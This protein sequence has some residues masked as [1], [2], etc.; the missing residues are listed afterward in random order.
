[1]ACLKA[2]ASTVGLM[3]VTIK[4]ISSR[5]TVADMVYGKLNK[6]GLRTIVATTM[7]TERQVME[8]ILG[9]MVGS[10]KEILTTTTVTGMANSTIQK[11]ACNTRASGTMESNRIARV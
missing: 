11:V 8:F 3:E 9:I 1:M 6:E 7:Q 5:A 2:L 4:E 10:T